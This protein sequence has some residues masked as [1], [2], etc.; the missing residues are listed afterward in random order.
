MRVVATGNAGRGVSG[1]RVRRSATPE[2][3][4][5]M[6]SMLERAWQSGG[7][8]R[9]RAML[10]LCL[11]RESS[12]AI[13]ALVMALGEQ[14]RTHGARR[15]REAATDM[16]GA[17][18]AGARGQ[19]N[20]FGRA[21]VGSAS[22]DLVPAAHSHGNATGQAVPR[23]RQAPALTAPTAWATRPPAPR[24]I[25]ATSRRPRR[26]A[27]SETSKASPAQALPRRQPRRQ[28][29][30]SPG[31][32]SERISSSPAGRRQPLGPRRSRQADRWRSRPAHPVRLA[33]RDRLS[34]LRS[35]LLTPAALHRR[36][37]ATRGAPGAAALAAGA[38]LRRRSA[39][40]V[41]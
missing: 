31:P 41:W 5:A 27:A 40:T 2:T 13:S 23:V 1:A 29:P 14:A 8:A 26:A 35:D 6:L 28:P 19:R 22:V 21:H 7:P 32:T 3:A 12:A 37:A 24:S 16:A 9:A 10:E 33:P 18:P 25:T 15:G 38:L 30:R 4:A 20:A 11:P 34:Q 17:P 36:R 39:P